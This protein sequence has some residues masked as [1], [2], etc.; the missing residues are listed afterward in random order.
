M[1][2]MYILAMRPHTKS[3]L[4]ENGIGPGVSPQIITPPIITAAVAELGLR[5]PA[6]VACAGAGRMVSRF[7]CHHTFGPAAAKCLASPRPLPGDAITHQG[8]GR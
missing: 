2:E 3:G 1:F 7:G 6:S 5:L 4:V 8:R